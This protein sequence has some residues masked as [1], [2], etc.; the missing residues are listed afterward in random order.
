MAADKK[1][2]DAIKEK[3]EADKATNAPPPP[4]LP[5]IELQNWYDTIRTS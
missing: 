5:T 1:L 2:Y 4:S 3:A